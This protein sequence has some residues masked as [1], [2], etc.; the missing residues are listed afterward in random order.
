MI[1][2]N[3]RNIR[4]QKGISMTDLAERALISKSYLSNIERNLKTNPTI[5]IILRI[6]KVLEVDLY[7]LLDLEDFAFQVV[8][9]TSDLT[10]D[11]NV[12]EKEDLELKNVND[13]KL[14]VEFIKWHRERATGLS[15]VSTTDIKEK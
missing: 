3:V 4:Q 10:R 2:E 15:K 1:G 9:G 5:D 13:Y 12:N 8:G 14:L 11:Y 6:S 7:E